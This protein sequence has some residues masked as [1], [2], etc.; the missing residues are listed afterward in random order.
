MK[1]IYK[2]PLSES[3]YLESEGAIAA[4]AP[5][6]EDGGDLFSSEFYSERIV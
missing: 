3:L 2:Q 4:S 6:Y 5:D 1:R